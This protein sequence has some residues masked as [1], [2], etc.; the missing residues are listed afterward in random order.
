[1][2]PNIEHILDLLA[3]TKQRIAQFREEVKTYEEPDAGWAACDLG[4]A[5]ISVQ[6]A[7]D[8]V[9][10]LVVNGP[11]PWDATCT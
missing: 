5:E 11:K 3:V 9:M 4:N 7:E 6:R 10:R 2:N 1:M 8:M